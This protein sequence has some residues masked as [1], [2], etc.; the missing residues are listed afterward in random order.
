M[1]AMLY[2]ADDGD[3]CERFKPT[4]DN[5]GR[6]VTCRNA[7]IVVAAQMLSPFQSFLGKASIFAAR[8]SRQVFA[9]K[10][11]GVADVSLRIVC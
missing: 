2:R 4:R 9:S 11:R 1:F 7:S 3:H 5:R 10:V 8:A 6:V